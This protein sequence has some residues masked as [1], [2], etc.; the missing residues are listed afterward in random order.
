MRS[1]IVIPAFNEADNIINV[2]D[3]VI[4]YQPDMSLLVVDDGSSDATALLAESRGAK[5]L[6]LP[7]NLG[8]G[9]AV[10]TGLMYALENEYDA[11]VLLDGDG[12]HDPQDIEVLTKMVA[13][14]EAELALGSRFLGLAGYDVPLTRRL[15]ISLFRTLTSFLTRQQITDPTSGFQVIG[16]R[17][18]EFFA[19][20][21]Y[22]YDFPD[23][24]IL[25]KLYYAGFKI[26]EVPVKLRPRRRG[27]SMHD[28]GAATLYYLYKMLFSIL[29]ILLQRKTL[30]EKGRH[31]ARNKDADLLYQP[32][33]N[34]RYY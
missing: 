25:I 32:H 15:G 26:R 14:G 3:D 1:L 9:A 18:L 28:G 7:F 29:I 4:R 17:V 6:R 2:I 21:N 10:Q 20:D 34:D 22:P 11:V 8:Y 30:A 24:D 12:Q 31:A 19:A 13:S 5:V 27:V 16:K 33:R 23:A